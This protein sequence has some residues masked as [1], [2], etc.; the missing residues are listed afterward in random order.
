MSVCVLEDLC[1]SFRSL[2]P[3]EA[4]VAVVSN[5]MVEADVKGR[6]VEACV[7]GCDRGRILR[8]RG[9]RTSLLYI[10]V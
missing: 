6:D 1:F 7:K 8:L 2:P 5:V 10:D 9:R 4:M 3:N